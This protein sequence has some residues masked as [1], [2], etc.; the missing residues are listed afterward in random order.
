MVT[1]GRAFV[2]SESAGA[3]LVLAK[4]K[5]AGRE[6]GMVWVDGGDQPGV[7]EWA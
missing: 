2:Q 5:A 1:V 3:R 6:F 4:A 7:V